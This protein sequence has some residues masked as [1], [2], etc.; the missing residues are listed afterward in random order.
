M[1]WTVRFSCCCSSRDRAIRGGR[2]AVSWIM[3]GHAV[4]WVIYFARALGGGGTAFRLISPGRIYHD[5]SWGWGSQKSA[6]F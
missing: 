3:L 1:L 6:R 4:L 2:T 5:D